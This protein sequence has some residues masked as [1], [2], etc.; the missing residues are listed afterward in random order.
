ME[1]KQVID[2]SLVEI[3]KEIKSKKRKLWLF[4]PVGFILG[5]IVAM[6]TP[7]EWNVSS[8]FMIDNIQSMDNSS[9]SGLAGL[10]GINLNKMSEE[11]FSP[12][13]FSV[14]VQTAPFHKALLDKKLFVGKAGGEVTVFEYFKNNHKP[15]VKDNVMK[16]LTYPLDKVK[17]IFSGEE[18]EPTIGGTN[19]YFSLSKEET[20]YAKI[21]S[22]NI[23]LS[24]DEEIGVF[25]L[26]VSLQ[27]RV[28]VAEVANFVI[29]Y[30]LKFVEQYKDIKHN[31]KLTFINDQLSSKESELE[32]IRINLYKFEESHKQLVKESADI[33][34]DILLDEYGLAFSML[35]L[36]KQQQEEVRLKIEEN[37]L[38]FK[39]IEPI[40]LPL[41]NFKPQR[42]LIIIG[43]FVLSAVLYAFV[44][45]FSLVRRKFKYVE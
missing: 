42:S 6:T 11:E 2:I 17:S 24:Y 29:D 41:K 8:S 31:N 36:L 45:V 34:R 35:K 1:T 14:L 4:L 18:A 40:K 28:I 3:L 30:M 22:A 13:L 39:E 7:K 26:S 33:E 12:D 23:G 16:M 15:S 25:N 37:K 27:D 43:F 32:S 44:Q 19:K 38:S 10:A 9:F 20:K 21:L 5:V